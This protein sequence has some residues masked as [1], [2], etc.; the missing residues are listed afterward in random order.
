[1]Q[2]LKINISSVPQLMS[3]IHFQD[4]QDEAV[5]A[6][7]TEYLKDKGLFLEIGNQLQTMI[8]ARAGISQ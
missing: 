3:Q 1:M 7:L 8:G 2:Q 5:Q 6:H 4:L